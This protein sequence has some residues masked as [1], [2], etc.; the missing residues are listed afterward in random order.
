VD[1]H[2][3]IREHFSEVLQSGDAWREGHRRLY[4]HLCATTEEGDE[5]TLEELQP[6]Y[7]AVAHGCRAGLQQQALDQVYFARI[8]RRKKDYSTRALGA[9][10]TD[11]AAVACFFE[12]PW[13][14]VLPDL[15]EGDRSWLLHRAAHHLRAL[16]R[17][18]EALDP[19]R[20][21]REMDLQSE[22]WE[23]ASISFRNL[24][25]LELTLGDV[26]RAVLDAERAEACAE[27]SGSW[28]ERVKRLTCYADALHQAGRRAEAE[29]RFRQ[30]EQMQAKRQ[31]KRRPEYRLL[32]SLRSVQYCDLLLAEAERAAWRLQMGGA[33]GVAGRTAAIVAC[34]EAERRSALAIKIAERSRRLLDIALHHLTM[35]RA[36]L[37]RSISQDADFRLLASYLPQIDR[38]MHGLRAAGQLQHLPPGFLTRA[39]VRMR[40]DAHA[41]AANAMGDLDEAWEIAE[42]GPMPLFMADIHLHR[43]RLFF[44]EPKYPWNRNPE[45]TPRGPKDDLAAARA[46]IERC[47]YWRRKEELEDAEAVINEAIRQSPD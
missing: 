8:Q 12:I 46:I 13:S 41:N 29:A 33:D 44:R 2:P 27:R 20:V 42:R 40:T 21:S 30:A 31:T 23:N 16:A 38:T 17:P 11:L 15:T 10:G 9:F 35:N 28:Q 7:Q 39:W 25:E 26:A 37:Y 4:E 19:M 34:R 18:A 1:A 22:Q 36:A 5:P 47:G 43:A 14:R 24:S 6:L 32:H 45:G 3:L